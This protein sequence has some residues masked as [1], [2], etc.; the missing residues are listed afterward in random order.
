[1]SAPASPDSASPG[2][3]PSKGEAGTTKAAAGT[4]LNLSP[5]PGPSGG[6]GEVT[7]QQ[8]DR[9]AAL[10]GV[11]HRQLRRWI[12][13]GREQND[14]CPLDDPV[15]MPAWIEKHL[16]KIRSAMRDRVSAAAEAA[17]GQAAS[18]PVSP[19]GEQAAVP[20]PPVASREPVV[21]PLDLSSVGGVEGETVSF[22]RQI[23]AG[24]KQQL[25]EAYREGKEERI[26]TL[27]ARLEKV[28]ESLRKQEI[29]AEAR[30]RRNGDLL[31]KS[32]VLNEIAQLLA[33]MKLM[34][35]QTARRVCSGLP[36][37]DP[38]TL[39]RIRRVLARERE[40]ELNVLRNLSTYRS[41]ADVLFAL[42]A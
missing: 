4:P 29:A 11:E 6:D 14:A 18:P 25:E 34:H 30:A 9:W 36:D 38:E 22:F 7:R 12:A 32:E 15:S 20:P 35:E 13:R 3:E 26:R 28:G 40:R 37:V 31:E 23:F 19:S 41:Q 5:E 1:M 10:Y 2:G 21:A 16:Q 33:T 39:D 8:L 17:R 24:V 42:A 27:H